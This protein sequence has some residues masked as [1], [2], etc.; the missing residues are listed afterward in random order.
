[1]GS[2]AHMQINRRDT[3][4]GV[5]SREWWKV[6][7]PAGCSPLS[8]GSPWLSPASPLNLSVTILKLHLSSALLQIQQTPSSPKIVSYSAGSIATCNCVFEAEEYVAKW[9]KVCMCK[10]FV[11]NAIIIDSNDYQHYG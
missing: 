10:A 6:L 7:E 1:M 9:A 2:N 5:A 4:P 3:R 11:D 8:R